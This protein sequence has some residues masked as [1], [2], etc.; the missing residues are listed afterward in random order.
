[1]SAC[2]WHRKSVQLQTDVFFF[3]SWTSPV[4]S[5]AKAQ[6][7]IYRVRYPNRSYI[8]VSIRQP[9]VKA[10]VT[11]KRDQAMQPVKPRDR[12]S[13]QLKQLAGLQLSCLR[14]SLWCIGKTPGCVRH[15]H[16]TNR[17][18]I[19][20]MSFWSDTR[21][22]QGVYW[23]KKPQGALK[24]LFAFLIFPVSQI[25]VTV[26]QELC[27]SLT[28][29]SWPF[30]FFPYYSHHTYFKSKVW[31]FYHWKCF[32]QKKIIQQRPGRTEG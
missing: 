32:T 1:M 22:R 6:E 3:L 7:V 23:H 12:F 25:I 24:W 29:L 19:R 17:H 4:H 2:V 15:P 31:I 18:D 9:A 26:K 8:Y 16:R 14:M 20:H 5:F 13:S 27:C 28:I 30:L 11:V 21:T 10:A